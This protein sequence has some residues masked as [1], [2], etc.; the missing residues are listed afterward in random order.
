MKQNRLIIILLLI[1]SILMGIPFLVPGCGAVALVAL[2]PLLCAERIA[3]FNGVKRFFWWYYLTF[4]IFNALTTWW[5]CKATVGGGIFAV[6][7]NSAF[8]SII[9]AL[10]RISKKRFRGCVPYIFLAV[11]WIAWER[12]YLTSSQI[13]WPWLVFGNAFGRTTGLVQW[14]EYTGLL[15]GSR[16]VWLANLSIVGILVRLSDGS[17]RSWNRK[18]RYSAAVGLALVII[19]PIV[20]SKVIY[21]HYRERA[22]AGRLEVLMAQSNFDPYQK[23]KAVPQSAQNR[24]VVEL[25]TEELAGR[26]TLKAYPQEVMLLMLP[27]TFCSDIWVSSPKNSPTW[28]TFSKNLVDKYPNVNL[29]FGASTHQAFYT[30]A[31]PSVLA[32]P[33]GGGDGWYLSYNTAYMTDGTG[34]VERTDK[35]KLVVGSELTPYPKIF[36]PIDDALGGLMG[37]CVSQGYA[38]NLNVVEYD[39]DGNVSRCIP[40][41]VPICY[42]S[43]Y[44]EFCTQYVRKGAQAICVITNDGWWGN[45][46][47][48]RQ[49]F[50]YSRLRA[51]ELRRDIA[52]CANTGISAFIDQRGDVLEQSKWWTPD[53]LHARINLTTKQTFFALYGDIVGR[54]CYMMFA[55]LFL[56][57]IVKFITKK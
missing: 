13:S 38:K 20:C 6:L 5:V 36:A 49:H 24:Q 44:P 22:D 46:A 17:F 12:F 32:R 48:Y 25:F 42:E 9:F 50:S 19:G 16:W 56:T 28:R 53:V 11:A 35:T 52:R 57:L 8:M 7:A 18:A 47:G 40:V 3:S 55:L 15:G 37:R 21:S 23:L 45:T 51:I 4:V 31:S 14:Y 2:V 10:F 43:I 41:G 1:S 39:E 34:R 30:H 33:L 54:L 26:D 29:L 27:E